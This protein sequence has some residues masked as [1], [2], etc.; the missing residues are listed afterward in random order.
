MIA[1]GGIVCRTQERLH[2]HQNFGGNPEVDVRGSS[3]RAN[4]GRIDVK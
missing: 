3:V 2:R 4:L 1:F